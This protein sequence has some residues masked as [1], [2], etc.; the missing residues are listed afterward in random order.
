MRTPIA[1]ALFAAAAC[2]G[3]GETDIE[4]TLRFA[5]R[6]DPEIVRLINAAA[7]TDMFMAESQID[8]FGDT[9]D[10]DPCPSIAISG[11]VAT[12][13]GG[14]TRLDGTQVQG[15]ATVTNPLGWDQIEDYDY[16]SDTVYEANQLVLIEESFTQSFD[17]VIRRGDNLTSWDADIT[18]TSFDVT[19]RSDLY[20]VC[21]NP[22]APRCTLSGSGLELPGIGGAQVSGTVTIDPDSGR[23]TA[24]FTLQ[25]ADR[26]TVTSDGTCVAW[27]IEG[28]DRG[29]TCP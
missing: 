1:I 22:S 8:Q 19:L 14:C 6:S 12:V 13:T 25:G 3:G 20:Y 17:G 26:L 2:G 5:D 4:A 10:D 11:T 28:T 7:G 27:S 21:T 16:G 24:E 23:Q 29:M 18:V 15:S 9:F